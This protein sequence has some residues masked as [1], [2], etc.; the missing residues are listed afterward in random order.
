MASYYGCAR[1][2]RGLNIE[3]TFQLN[4]APIHPWTGPCVPLNLMG[5]AMKRTQAS[6]EMILSP[7]VQRAQSSTTFIAPVSPTPLH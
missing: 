4:R 3:A 7:W 6:S 2:L 1:G 5:R